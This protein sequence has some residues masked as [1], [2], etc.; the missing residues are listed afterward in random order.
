[1]V[2]IGPAYLPARFLHHVLLTYPAYAARMQIAP[3]GQAQRPQHQQCQVVAG[4]VTRLLCPRS[5][6]HRNGTATLLKI[7]QSGS[8]IVTTLHPQNRSHRLSRANQ[9]RRPMHRQTVLLIPRPHVCG[10]LY[11][12]HL[13]QQ[14]RENFPQLP[15]LHHQKVSRRD[16]LLP[17]MLIV[18][19]QPR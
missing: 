17:L 9:Q 2:I 7:S 3:S 15:K 10:V 11:L 14:R 16:S 5:R 4:G 12:T 19:L 6:C 18:Y 8:R 1:M 13:H